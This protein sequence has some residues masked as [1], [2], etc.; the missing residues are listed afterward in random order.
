MINGA[1]IACMRDEQKGSAVVAKLTPYIYST[2]AKSQAEFYVQAL[3]GEIHAVMMYGQAPHTDE[4]MKDKVMH[5]MMTAGGNRFYMADVSGPVERGSGMDLSIELPSED[6]AQEAFDKLSE[7]GR[8]VMP[9]D[10]QFWGA[11]FGRIEDKYGVFWQ[12]STEWKG[13]KP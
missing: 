5:L 2:D 13:E 1:H 7:G 12:V 4:A 9:L 6:E 8:V 11:L 3:G 10:K